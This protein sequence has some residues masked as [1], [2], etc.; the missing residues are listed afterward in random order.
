MKFSAPE[1]ENHYALW[2]WL[3]KNPDKEKGNWPGFYTMYKLG[4]KKPTSSCFAC[5]FTL[6]HHESC[7]MCPLGAENCDEGTPFDLWAR[8]INTVGN[9]RLVRDMWQ[10]REDLCII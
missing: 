1:K 5:E 8:R 7:S 10:E 6:K 2:N 9:A 4:I 3:S